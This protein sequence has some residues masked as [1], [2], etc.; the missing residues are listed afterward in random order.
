MKTF[1]E[2]RKFARSLN[3]KSGQE[4]NE[5]CKSGKLPDDI[6]SNPNKSYINGWES[7]GDFLGTGNIATKNRQY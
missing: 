4:W 3:L 1:K 5:Y 6:P 2:A 7:M